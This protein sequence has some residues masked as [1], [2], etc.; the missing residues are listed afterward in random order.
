MLRAPQATCSRL[1]ALAR[2]VV[3]L[4]GV[5]SRAA[6]SRL[7]ALVRLVVVLACVQ[8]RAASSRLAARAPQAACSRLAALARRA[9]GPVRGLVACW[10]APAR[11]TLGACGSRRRRWGVARPS[12][13]AMMPT[14]V[15]STALMSRTLGSRSWHTRPGHPRWGKLEHGSGSAVRRGL[16]YVRS[17]VP[18]GRQTPGGRQAVTPR[19]L[20]PMRRGAPGAT[21]M[22]CER[23]A[24]AGGGKARRGMASAQPAAL[25]GR[26]S[27]LQLSAMRSSTRR[28][29]GW[30]A[31]SQSSMPSSNRSSGRWGSWARSSPACE[32]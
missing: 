32:P 15:R 6:S 26:W 17:E 25:A 28:W 16:P 10:R 11:G 13:S 30:V 19:W 12:R 1:A 14:T 18:D 21:S 2:L 29:A 23:K 9:R 22:Q 4:A 24:C 27:P 31:S 3:V 8:S 20:R 5:Q 7:A